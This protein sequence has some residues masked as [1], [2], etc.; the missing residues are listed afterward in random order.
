MNK[1]VSGGKKAEAT[2]KKKYG[3]DFYVKLGRLGGV[4]KHPNKGFRSE[5]ARTAGQV[6][7][8]RS[9]KGKKLIEVTEKTLVYRVTATGEIERHPNPQFE[10]GK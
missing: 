7:G 10:E 6:G 2:L 5:T 3:Q 4:K 9:K 1:R 8:K